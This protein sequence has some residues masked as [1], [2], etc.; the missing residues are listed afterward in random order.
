[1]RK[2][3]L[4]VQVATAMGAMAVFPAIAQDKQAPGFTLEEVIVTAQKRD[5]NSQSVPISIQAFGAEGMEKLGATQ[6]FDLSKS[7]PSLSASGI[8]GSNST[9]GLRGVIDQSRNIGIDA[10][11]GVYI[12]GV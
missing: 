12:D 9:S 1:M 10:R 4:A 2:T 5:E 3:I 6:L 8:P 11:M 7:A